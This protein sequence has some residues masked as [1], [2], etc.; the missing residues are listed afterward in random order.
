MSENDNNKPE[1]EDK[2]QDPFNFFKLA[3]NDDEGK[4]D[5]KKDD[6]DKKRFPFGDLC[7]SFWL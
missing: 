3:G 7:L 2:N 5:D 6:K 4:N 1:N